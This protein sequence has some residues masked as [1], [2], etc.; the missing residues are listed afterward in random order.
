M[1]IVL[2]STSTEKLA[3]LQETLDG[4]LA[5]DSLTGQG[6]PSGI[7]VQPLSATETERGARNRAQNAFEATDADLAIGMEGGLEPVEDLYHLVCAVC[8]YDGQ[9]FWVATSPLL[10]LPD[11]VSHK[12]FDGGEYGQVVR[13]Y[14]SEHTY[15]LGH[16]QDVLEELVSRHRSFA[17][18]IRRAFLKYQAANNSA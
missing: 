8:F 4:L 10:S 15:L 12:I 3:V 6:V 9:E 16:D 11:P 1:R 5:F 18:A 17:I 7:P 14:A 2:G 13:D